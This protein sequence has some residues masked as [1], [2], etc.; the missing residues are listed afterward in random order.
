MF[1]NF[2]TIVKIMFFSVVIGTYQ[3]INI[4]LM[5]NELPCDVHFHWP[6][7]LFYLRAIWRPPLS[8]GFSRCVED[9]LVMLSALR[10]GCCLFDIFPIS[11]FICECIWIMLTVA[12]YTFSKTNWMIDHR[13]SKRPSLKPWSRH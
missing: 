4:S 9:P 5:L 10:S 13:L 2:S 3:G 7:T 8:G 6:S 1:E 12:I 11:V